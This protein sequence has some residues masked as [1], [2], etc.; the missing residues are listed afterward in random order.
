[1]RKPFAELIG[2]WQPEQCNMRVGR[3]PAQR[4]Q[5]RHSTEEVA[6]K[7]G[8]DNGDLFDP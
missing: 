8:A 5:R 1:M 7:E 2:P 4:S 6:E 3:G